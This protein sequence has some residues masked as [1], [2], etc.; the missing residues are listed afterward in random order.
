MSLIFQ[1]LIVK[2]LL[3]F[4]FVF[5]KIFILMTFFRL[6]GFKLL[7]PWKIRWFWELF[8]RIMMRLFLHR[9]CMFLN[10]DLWSLDYRWSLIFFIRF[11]NSFGCLFKRMKIFFRRG[12]KRMKFNAYLFRLIFLFIFWLKITKIAKI[13]FKF[14]WCWGEKIWIIKSKSRVL[15][16]GIIIKSKPGIL[17]KRIWISIALKIKISEIRDLEGIWITSWFKL[18]L[19]KTLLNI[20]FNL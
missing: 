4:S 2:L 14:L 10:K 13:I 6:W 15:L 5:K 9:F 20:R 18:K 17:G 7:V 19:L 12:Y 11:V 8:L 1:I 16:K 3:E